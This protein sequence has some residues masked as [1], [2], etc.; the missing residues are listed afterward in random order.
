MRC[1]KGVVVNCS[2]CGI[3][4]VA[5]SKKSKYCSS[6]CKSQGWRNKYSKEQ[7]KCLICNNKSPSRGKYCSKEC[8]N[9]H[10]LLKNIDKSQTYK[11]DENYI[12][13]KICGFYAKDLSKHISY[14]HCS[15]EEYHQIFPN[16]DIRGLSYRNKQSK[17]LHGENNPGYQHGGKF[18][19]FS[20]KF[21]GS[22][23]KED[24]IKKANKTRK[25]NPHKQPT[26][27][28]YYL[29]NE[30]NVNWDLA[31]YLLKERQATGRKENFINRYGEIEGIIRW[32]NRQE[33]WLKSMPKTN[34]SMISQELFWEI[35]D[36][37]DIEDVYFAELSNGVAD[38]SGKNNEITIRHAHGWCKPDFI[39]GN[40]IIEFDGEYWHSGHV[41]KNR[42]NIREQNLKNSGYSV[43]RIKEKEYTKNKQMVITECINFLNK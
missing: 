7:S 30:T 35:V 20:D 2:V 3:G 17:R 11:D 28:E 38:F 27:V 5:K 24:I 10:I 23:I 21:I 34:F 1:K 13:C 8:R 37:I 6:K 26:R 15:V 33:K 19:P 42:D 41:S 16:S 32:N 25:E 9:L 40:N 12:M 18:S 14:Q 4:Y 29:H 31:K 39:K 22:S 43:L 36:K